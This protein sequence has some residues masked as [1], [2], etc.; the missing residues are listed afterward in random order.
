MYEVIYPLCNLP[1]ETG[2]WK[3][4]PVSNCYAMTHLQSIVESHSHFQSH[5]PCEVEVD[6]CRHF[7]VVVTRNSHKAAALGH[8][9]VCSRAL[10]PR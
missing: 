4:C 1:L 6:C 2:F 7:E 9:H 3:A 8:S 5:W 10:G